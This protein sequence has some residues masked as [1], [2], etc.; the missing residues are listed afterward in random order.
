MTLYNFE[1]EKKVFYQYQAKTALTS[2][3]ITY[4]SIS[5]SFS[6]PLSLQQAA[7][8]GPSAASLYARP[9]PISL[10]S[11]LLSSTPISSG[12][13]VLYTST[14]SP[15]PIPKQMKICVS[16]H[17]QEQ[18]KENDTPKAEENVF[19]SWHFSARFHPNPHSLLSHHHQK[20]EPPL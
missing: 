11:P 16:T 1:D 20:Q 14:T 12:E 13:N 2:H 7:D 8:S 15:I 3:S 9:S 18:E 5:S 17:F 4:L 6:P 10:S 19:S